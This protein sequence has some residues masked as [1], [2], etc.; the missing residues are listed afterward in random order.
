MSRVAFYAPMKPPDHPTPSG[1]R[2]IARLMQRAL[3]R[4]GYGVTVASRLRARDGAGDPAVQRS[5]ARAARIEADRLVDELRAAPPALWFTYHCY[6]K[7]P[8]LIGP[9]VA[10]A[11]GVPYVVAEGSRAPRRLQGPWA[12]FAR[13]AED[14]L[15]AAAVIFW[16]TFRDLPALE[17]AR[18]AG[19]RLVHLPPFTALGQPAVRPVSTDG[20][21]KLVAVA[22]MRAGD[23]LDSFRALAAG[24]GAARDADW[25]LTIVGDGEAEAQV[26]AA[27]ASLGERVVFVGRRDDR[28]SLHAE[29]EAA[30]LLVWPGVNEAFG[31]VYLEAQAMGRACVAEDR[32]GVRDVLAPGCPRVPPGDADAF[33]A[34]VRR[35]AADRAALAAAGRAAR[36]HMAAHH[37]I[38]AAAAV[39]RATLGPLTD[40]ASAR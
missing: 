33:G 3:E 7:A 4:A 26:R 23:K 22:M 38:R 2:R 16:P 28:P 35:F 5:L 20:P 21:L 8:D 18:P 1:D 17:A 9:R 29:Y 39:L 27:F 15:D 36:A 11:L 25:S 31:M 24:L 40:A 37:G 14:A 32:P 34:A 13:A 10:A 30:D 6:W 12:D 19:Q